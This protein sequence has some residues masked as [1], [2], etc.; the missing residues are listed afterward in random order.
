MNK[1]TNG[2][3]G[4]GMYMVNKINTTVFL[5]RINIFLFDK[6]SMLTHNVLHV[7]QNL[8]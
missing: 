6:R 2:C 7:S 3:L 8:S 1:K 4:K 5:M